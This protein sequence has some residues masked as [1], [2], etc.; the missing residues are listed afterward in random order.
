[1][2][3]QVKAFPALDAMTTY[4]PEV[5]GD[6]VALVADGSCWLEIAQAAIALPDFGT[7]F[8]LH[9]E[10][11]ASIVTCLGNTQF[12]KRWQLSFGHTPA[13][14][15]STDMPMAYM[16]GGPAEDVRKPLPPPLEP[17]FQHMKDVTGCPFNQGVV[18]WYG[19]GGDHMP[20][21]QDWV[22]GMADGDLM[23]VSTLTMCEG[24][25]RHFCIMPVEAA[26]AKDA[27]F[28]NGLAVPCDHGRIITMCGSAIHSSFVHGVPRLPTAGPSRRIS[29]TARR[30]VE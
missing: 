3:K 10:A 11:R 5:H 23:R 14:P 19:E 22:H 29:L 26:M 18:V 13:C 28:P 30:F 8:D 16:F 9:P 1:M 20:P 25:P 27:T 4:A 24:A 6:K 12:R 17:V 15:P 21:H 7:T 2:R